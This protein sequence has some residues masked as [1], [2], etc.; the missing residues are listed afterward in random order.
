MI[1][2]CIIDVI[3]TCSWAINVLKY[4]EVKVLEK[5]LK[6]VCYKETCAVLRYQNSLM[7]S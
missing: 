7:Q 3:F 1:V 6:L 2:N 4:N 5:R